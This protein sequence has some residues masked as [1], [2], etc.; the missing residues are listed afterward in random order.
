ME[1]FDDLVSILKS[2]FESYSP[3]DGEKSLRAI[4]FTGGELFTYCDKEIVNKL[5]RDLPNDAKIVGSQEISTMDEAY[6]VVFHSSEWD[7][8]NDTRTLP[9]YMYHLLPYWVKLK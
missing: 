7:A 2:K 4:C 5:K 9:L 3:T 1:R 6:Q 8:P